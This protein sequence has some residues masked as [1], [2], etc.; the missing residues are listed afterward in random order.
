MR[1]ILLLPTLCKKAIEEA[2]KEKG[3]YSA[4]YALFKEL[5]LDPCIEYLSHLN[6]KPEGTDA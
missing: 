5:F 1:G 2:M 6:D 3:N 4:E